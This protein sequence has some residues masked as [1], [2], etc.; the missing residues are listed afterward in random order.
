MSLPLITMS[1]SRE[2]RK[3]VIINVFVGNIKYTKVADNELII[4]YNRRLAYLFFFKIID[5]FPE[6]L[7][8]SGSSRIHL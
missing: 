4:I 5:I 3:I 7:L 8:I 6:T 2:K 1:A